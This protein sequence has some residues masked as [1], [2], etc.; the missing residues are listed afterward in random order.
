MGNN[1]SNGPSDK[2]L[3][4]IDASLNNKPRLEIAGVYQQVEKSTF[5]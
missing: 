3:R 1:V 4:E 5:Y 2:L